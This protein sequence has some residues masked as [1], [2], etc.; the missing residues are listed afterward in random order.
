MKKL[1][2]D[3]D[4]AVPICEWGGPARG[5]SWGAEDLIVYPFNYASGLMQVRG[6]G[7]KPTPLTELDTDRKERTHRWPQVVPGHDVVLFTVDTTDT[8]ESY[9]DAHIDALRLSTGERKTVFEGAGF[10]RYVP[11]GHLVIGRGGFLFG[12]PFDIE[13]LEVTGTPTPV[14]EG[15]VGAMGG[16][17]NSGVL[18]ASIAQN[19]LLV[20]LTGKSES[21]RSQLRW[22]H[23][24]GRDEP[25]AGTPVGKYIDPMLSP[26]GKYLAVGVGGD[27]SFNIWVFDLERG[28]RTRLTFEGENSL[29][30][31]MPDGK[32]VLFS[33][34]RDGVGA[35]YMTAAD[36]SGGERLVHAVE[37]TSI[38]ASD[39]SPDGRLVALC[40]LGGGRTK[41]DVYVKSLVDHDAEAIPFLDGA[42]NEAWPQFSPD[43][44]W[45]V[46]ES[47]ETGNNQVFVRPYPGPGGKWQISTRGGAS[48]RWSSDGRR[49]H[50]R[51][52]TEWWVVDVEPGKG[53]PFQS[54]VPRL[55]RNDLPLAWWWGSSYSISPDGEAMLLA[56]LDD[57]RAAPVELTVVV[58]WLAELERLVLR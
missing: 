58:N 42:S 15:V 8:P 55:V 4:T 50:Y 33:S 48:P 23:S 43:A 57:N 53:P 44:R 28:S 32:S 56:V 40:M 3:G 13:R 34:V 39:V 51:I 9:D 35:T 26:D 54:G 22:L 25:L 6:S 47:D 36:G 20:Y 46:Y 38:V 37:G 5:A 24:D 31:W 17:F 18:H 29:P 16:G 1:Q 52:D 2:I 41:T 27:R 30:L 45:I 10:A 12:M 19:G 7:G 11:T 49:I 14:V 21:P